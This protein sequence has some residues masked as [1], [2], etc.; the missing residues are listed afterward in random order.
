MKPLAAEALH[1]DDCLPSSD[2]TTQLVQLPLLKMFWSSLQNSFKALPH[3]FEYLRYLRLWEE[4]VIYGN[5]RVTWRQAWR[6]G[7]DG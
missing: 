6:G 1:E 4:D 2:E 3:S 7:Q 5:G